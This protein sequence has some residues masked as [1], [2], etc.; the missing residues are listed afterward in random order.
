MDAPPTCI[1]SLTTD[2]AAFSP[3]ELKGV[4]VRNVELSKGVFTVAM[5]E[6]F[7]FFFWRMILLPTVRADGNADRPVQFC[8]RLV[9]ALVL[10][11]PVGAPYGLSSSCLN[12]RRLSGDILS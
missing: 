5:C 6:R 1:A 10:P 3:D 11:E 12:L 7:V 4:I 2:L 8:G 9:R